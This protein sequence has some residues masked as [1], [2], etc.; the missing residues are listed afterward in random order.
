MLR[1][2]LCAGRSES[3]GM[4][5]AVSGT[6]LTNTLRSSRSSA[7]RTY[8]AKL[9]MSVPSFETTTVKICGSNGDDGPPGGRISKYGTSRGTVL[10][11]GGHDEYPCVVL[12]K[13]VP[14][15]KS[16]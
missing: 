4:P 13:K 10:Y 5:P 1:K 3:S 11:S 2:S 9:A 14:Y 6:P 16:R 8:M 7:K 15:L 12:K